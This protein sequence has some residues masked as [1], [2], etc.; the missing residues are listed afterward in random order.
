MATQAVARPRPSAFRSVRALLASPMAPFYLVLGSVTVLVGLGLLMVLSASAAMAQASG[1]SPYFYLIRQARS[2]AV[3]LVPAAILVFVPPDVLRRFGWLAWGI[4]VVL[5]LLVLTPLGVGSG[6]N[7]NWLVLGPVQIQPS[8][9]AKLALVVWCGT[10]FHNKRGRLHE[11]FQLAIPF[12]PLGGLVLVL[13]LAG[14]DLGTGIILGLILVLILWFV[15]T[16]WK[17]L[18]PSFTLAV[19]TMVLLVYGSGNRMSRIAIFLDPSSD[20]DLSSQPI[21]ALYALASGGWWG[22]GLGAGRQKWGGLKDG[23]HTDFIFAVLGEELGLFGVLLV[24]G[25]FA[26]LAWAG[27]EIALRSDKMFNRI[28]AAGLTGWFVVQAVINIFVVM[29]L[30]PVLGVPLPFMSYGGSALMASLM[31]VGVLLS[32]ARD[33]PAA[34][35]YRA[36]RPSKKSRPRMTSVMAATKED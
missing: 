14:R 5:L 23:A 19:V 33:T 34:R 9:F 22:A 3:G 30:L 12:V 1:V 17:V 36:S 4:A 21:A 15:G 27:L 6:G 18:V 7:V 2:L 32:I 35:T 26:L 31:G 13:V 10:I 29:H 24:I 11:V 28:V 25:L 8:E 16:S 20:T